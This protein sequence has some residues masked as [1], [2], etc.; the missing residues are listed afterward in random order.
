MPS[1]TARRIAFDVGFDFSVDVWP[2][3]RSAR[4]SASSSIARS[5][6]ASPVTVRDLLAV[7]V[8]SAI[9]C[10]MRRPVMRS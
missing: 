7:N 4:A 6:A 8:P 9:W 2:G 1:P 3:K 10:G 5:A